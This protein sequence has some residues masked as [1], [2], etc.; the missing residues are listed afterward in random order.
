M[1]I[2]KIKPGP[3]EILFF[4]K[5]DQEFNLITNNHLAKLKK[6]SGK[7][8]S[9]GLVKFETKEKFEKGLEILRQFEKEN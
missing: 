7:Y 3:L 9:M 5:N 2:H 6:S 1:K 4:V 8:G